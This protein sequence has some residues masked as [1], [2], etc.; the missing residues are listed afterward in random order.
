MFTFNAYGNT[1]T[2]TQED[3][4]KARGNNVI[5]DGLTDMST[6]MGI[7]NEKLLWNAN[8]KDGMWH[9]VTTPTV[10]NTYEWQEGYYY[11]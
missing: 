3:I 11:D 9:D 7:A 10:E 4:S 5:E 2:V 8:F 1:L 6:A